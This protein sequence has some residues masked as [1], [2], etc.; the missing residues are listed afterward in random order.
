MPKKSAQLVQ[1]Q[2]LEVFLA[3]FVFGII[4]VLAM[5]PVLI[6]MVLLAIVP[7]MGIIIDIVAM[8]VLAVIVVAVQQYYTASVFKFFCEGVSAKPEAAKASGSKPAKKRK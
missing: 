4:L 7:C 8:L 2:T 3:E 1:G 5:I 6:V